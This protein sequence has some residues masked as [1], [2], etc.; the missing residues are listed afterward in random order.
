MIAFTIKYILILEDISG[1]NVISNLQGFSRAVLFPAISRMQVRFT[2]CGKK[3]ILVCVR[4]GYT[5][6]G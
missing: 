2:F 4:V 6:I 3:G 5:R 1:Y